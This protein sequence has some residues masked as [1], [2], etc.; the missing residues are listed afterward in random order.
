MRRLAAVML[1]ALVSLAVSCGGEAKKKTPPTPPETGPVPVERDGKWGF[2][3]TD[4]KIFITPRYDEV[5]RFRDG[6]AAV[7]NGNQWWFINEQGRNVSSH[8]LLHA[9]DFKDGLARVQVDPAYLKTSETAKWAVLD[10][11]GRFVIEPIYDE[12]APFVNRRAAARIGDKTVTLEQPE[13]PPVD[14][15][16]DG[17]V[18]PKESM[19]REGKE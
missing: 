12:L 5:R 7:R 15:P 17:P 3:D 11:N 19:N 1:V 9:D 4:G 8:A 18:G 14:V 10:R 13:A 16:S 6:L 2:A